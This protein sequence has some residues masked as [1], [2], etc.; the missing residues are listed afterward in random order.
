MAS[1]LGQL[2]PICWRVWPPLE[3]LAVEVPQGRMP[4]SAGTNNLVVSD[5]FLTCILPLQL[6]AVVVEKSVATGRHTLQQTYLFTL[7]NKMDHV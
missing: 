1:P 6:C 4:G 3:Q 5:W 7:Q 2:I